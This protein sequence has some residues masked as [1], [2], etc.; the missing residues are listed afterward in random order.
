MSRCTSPLSPPLLVCV[1]P[2]V[3]VCLISPSLPPSLPPSSPQVLHPGAER[4]RPYRSRG[5]VPPP[6]PMAPPHPLPL[7]ALSQ[8]AQTLAGTSFLL[9]S[10]SPFLPSIFDSPPSHVSSLPPSPPGPHRPQR[11][12]T[13]RPRTGLPLPP[14]LPPALRRRSLAAGPFDGWL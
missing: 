5:P 13:V 7:P 8:P 3:V 4:K 1:S 6:R 10:L 12:R 14:F 11:P 2:S 9:P